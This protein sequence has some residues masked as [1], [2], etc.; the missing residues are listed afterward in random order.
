MARWLASCL[1]HGVILQKLEINPKCLKGLLMNLLGQNAR[2]AW[3]CLAN[4]APVQI[5][6]ILTWS[7]YRKT[8][9]PLR[10]STVGTGWGNCSEIVLVAWTCLFEL[11]QWNSILQ[12]CLFPV[13]PTITWH[14]WSEPK[15]RIVSS[16]AMSTLRQRGFIDHWNCF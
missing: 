4:T 9:D 8:S 15:K 13:S 14:I 1:M 3:P 11:A 7:S 10:Y 5:H 6:S 16:T 2:P 12:E